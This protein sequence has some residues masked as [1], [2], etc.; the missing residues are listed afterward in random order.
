MTRA[1]THHV[2]VGNS[3]AGIEAA[4]ALRNRD[5]AARITVIGDEHPHPFSRTA[6]MYVFCGQLTLKDTQ[7]YPEDLYARMRFERVVDRVVAVD[8]AARTLRLRAGGTLRYDTL[9]LAVGSVARRLAEPDPAL[10]AFV[11]LDDL[12]RLDAAARPGMSAAVVGGGLIG[13]EAAEMLQHRGLR[14]HFVIRE[15]A[16]FPVALDDEESAMVADH[17]REHGVDCRLGAPVHG[18]ARRGER[19]HLDGPDLDV[20]LV[21]AAIGVRP[22]TEFLADSGIAVHPDTG[23]IE[24]TDALASTTAP[25]VYAAG[26]CA[27][28]TWIDGTRRPEQ[29]WYT[30]RDQGRAAAASMLGDPVRY[31]RTSWYNAAR[32]FDLE[33]T[34]AGFIPP[35]PPGPGWQRWF[36]RQPDAPHCLRI[37]VK[38]GAVKGFN[39]V[40][41][42]WDTRVWLRW[43][44][45][46]R[47][48]DHVLAHLP[49]AQ[50]DAEFTPRFRVLPGATLHD[51]GG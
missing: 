29:L 6:L 48:L 50:F 25:G 46:R 47:P 18:V 11:T 17:I 30:A 27:Q 41:A 1:A 22:A 14:T 13:V 2:I 7:F 31:R 51:G 32:F 38:D 9:L 12:R 21:V 49:E 42:R 10:H 23:G 26:D 39:A 15:P 24:T 3:I 28:V 40:G 43:I 16:Y 20:D 37:V 5:A 33:Y 44:Q 45:E 4:I 8:S 34:T 19:L 35:G 36:Q